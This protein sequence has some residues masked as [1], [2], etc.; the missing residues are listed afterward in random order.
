MSRVTLASLRSELAQRDEHIAAL[1][2]HI[3]ALRAESAAP[4]TASCAPRAAWTVT[5][6][7]QPW[8][9]TF[10]AND[11]YKYMRALQKRGAKAQYRPVH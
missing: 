5:L 8:L 3:V 1:Q 6:D 4:R 7:G 10:R 11:A 9:T 2:A